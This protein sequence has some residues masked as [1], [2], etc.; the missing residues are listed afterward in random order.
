VLALDLDCRARLAR[1]ARDDIGIIDRARQ[2]QLDRYA[3]LQLDVH[4][5]NDDAHSAC[6]EQVLDAVLASQDFTW[7]DSRKASI[8]RLG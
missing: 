6:A 3:F 5:G 2:Q 1:K 7:L 8:C 4:R